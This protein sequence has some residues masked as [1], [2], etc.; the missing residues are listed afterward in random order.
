MTKDLRIVAL[1]EHVSFRSFTEEIPDATKNARGYRNGSGADAQAGALDDVGDRR[2]AAM[3]A[4]GIDVQVLSVIGPGADLLP[5][6]A[7]PDHARRYNDRLAEVVRARP[8]RYSAFAHLPM[9]AP[10]AAADELD[11]AASDLGFVG[12]LVNGLTEDR[13]LDDARFEPILARA[14]KLEVPIYLHPNIPP[15]A[16]RNAYYDGFDSAVSFVL[17]TAGWGWHAEIA[18]HIL[19]LVLAGTFDR[20]PALRLIIGHA[21]EGLPLM[22]QRFDDTLG[23]VAKHLRKPVSE[24]IL[25][26]VLLTTSGFFTAPPFAAAVATFGIDRIL[27]SVDY[28]F[29]DN[30]RARKFLDDLDL[31]AEA[32][33]K[34]AH[35]NAG[36][37]LKLANR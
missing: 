2:L 4:A 19:R 17:A 25:D 14:E 27:F 22:M 21:G 28:P 7:A 23:K 8:D 33:E 37:V 29:A 1:E 3:D 32:R 10:E 26:H 35:G 12:A 6:A 15:A 30:Q 24:T 9:T 13:F 11:R 34:V 18:V 5:P 16:V 36:R 20:H 31:T